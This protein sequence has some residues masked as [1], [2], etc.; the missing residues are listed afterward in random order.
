MYPVGKI[1]CAPCAAAAAAAAAVDCFEEATVGAIAVETC[2]G[3]GN[4]AIDPFGE[5]H[6]FYVAL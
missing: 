2:T 6:V 5:K 4:T 3:A 1:W